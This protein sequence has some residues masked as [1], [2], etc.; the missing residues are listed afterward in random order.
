M[1]PS[2]RLRS[3]PSMKLKSPRHIGN[4]IWELI[5]RRPR[6]SLLWS[7]VHRVTKKSSRLYLFLADHFVSFSNR[8]SMVL[9]TDIFSF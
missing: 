1:N 9:N 6:R 5:S 3:G 7:L 8:A 4:T 2:S